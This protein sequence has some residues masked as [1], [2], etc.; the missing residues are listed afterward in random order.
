MSEPHLSGGSGAPWAIFGE[1]VLCER[2]VFF[3][4]L[5]FI[6]GLEVIEHLVMATAPPCYIN[7]V[8]WSNLFFV[9]LHNEVA[10][11]LVAGI[12]I[13]RAKELQKHRY[14]ISFL[15]QFLP[16]ASR[17]SISTKLPL[18]ESGTAA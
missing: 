4:G 14:A 15:S 7:G 9:G 10:L 6:L 5:A 13:Q 18:K 3:L 17:S 8:Y 12:L 11:F 16:S 1:P 2:P